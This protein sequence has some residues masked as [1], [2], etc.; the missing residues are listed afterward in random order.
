MVPE[1]VDVAGIGEDG[2]EFGGGERGEGKGGIL[3]EEEEVEEVGRA[4]GGGEDGADLDEEEG[5]G[6]G[7]ER[8]AEEVGVEFGLW[9]VLVLEEDG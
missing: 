1:E 3:G 2:E 5:G 4:I 7:R 9:G 6:G 8:E